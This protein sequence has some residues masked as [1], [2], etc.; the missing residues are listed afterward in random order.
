M[1][2]TWFDVTCTLC[3]IIP[4]SILIDLQIDHRVDVLCEA[5][6]IVN[7]VIVRCMKISVGCLN[8]HVVDPL[9]HILDQDTIISKLSAYQY[10][11]Y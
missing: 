1:I 6:D 10:L 11:Y 7:T 4:S 3:L 9:L 8:V 2:V 5:C